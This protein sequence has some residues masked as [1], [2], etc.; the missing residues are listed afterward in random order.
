MLR[1]TDLHC[2]TSSFI[3]I[4]VPPG[5]SSSKN[6]P[7]NAGD[8]R[9]VGSIPRSRRSVK[10]EMAT[11]SSILAWKILWTEESCGLQS[12]R[13]QRGGHGWPT[14]HMHML[15]PKDH[16]YWGLPY[17]ISVDVLNFQQ[18]TICWLLFIVDQFCL[19]LIHK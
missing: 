7:A 15:T 12:M 8:T 13:S 6:P 18:Y 4:H 1:F 2:V 11:H 9:D 3:D 16:F 19:F 5:W 14:E 17:I 10:M